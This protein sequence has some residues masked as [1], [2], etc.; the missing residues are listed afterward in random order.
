L[1]GVLFS[2]AA[3][4]AGRPDGGAAVRIKLFVRC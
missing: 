2:G 3:G 1:R 4:D